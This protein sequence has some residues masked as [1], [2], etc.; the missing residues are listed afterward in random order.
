MLGV[1][2]LFSALFF[3]WDTL[4]RWPDRKEPRVRRIIALNLAFI[5]MTLWLLNL[6]SSATSGMCLVL[7]CLVL[8]LM[9]FEP[10]RRRPKLLF[11]SIPVVFCLY[12]T[13]SFWFGV[14]LNSAIARAVGRDPT[15]TGRT[16]IWETLLRLNT[17]SIVGTGYESFWLGPRLQTIWA[18]RGI[19]NEAHN[20][21]LE[22]YLNLGLVGL[23]LLC[24]FLIGSYRHIYRRFDA[25]VSLGCLGLTVW[26]VMLFYNLTEAAFQNGLLWLTFLSAGLCVPDAKTRTAVERQSHRQMR[27]PHVARG[28]ARYR[29]TPNNNGPGAQPVRMSRL[30]S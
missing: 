28:R 24:G 21:Y 4:T 13:L 1:L 19:I 8:A 11:T 14:D 9:Q 22:I 10:I 7:G 5:V 20:G 25:G 6:S 27:D 30:Q 18:Q 26:T 2:C 16:L 23:C 29:L 12:A 3:V 15:L 17:N